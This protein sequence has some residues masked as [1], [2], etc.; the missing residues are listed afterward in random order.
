MYFLQGNRGSGKTT[1]LLDWL[2]SGHVL[3]HG[4]WSRCLLM[5]TEGEAEY[6]RNQ[7]A[8]TLR[9]EMHNPAERIQ[10]LRKAIRAV[11][12]VRGLRGL[13]HE[14]EYAVDN[15]DNMLPFLLG[16]MKMPKIMTSSDVVEVD[17]IGPGG[18]IM[19]LREE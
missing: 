14:I 12:G 1:Y 10:Q 13:P 2:R 9:A 6:A 17:K 16:T 11:G 18:R 15:I 5:N 8:A 7:I 3:E 19:P 4:T